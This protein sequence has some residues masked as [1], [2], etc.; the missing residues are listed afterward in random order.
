M[1][2][3][4]KT[5]S[6]SCQGTF[7][8]SALVQ[9]RGNA[10]NI[11]PSPYCS[12]L[13]YSHFPTVSLDL[14]LPPQLRLLGYFTWRLGALQSGLRRYSDIVGRAHLNS[15]HQSPFFCPATAEA[16]TL[17]ALCAGGQFPLA[18]PATRDKLYACCSMHTC[19]SKGERECTAAS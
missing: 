3:R 16:L 7:Q 5:N 2:R 1:R 4:G 11:S 15:A 8:Q 6:P 12:P 19:G 17:Q 10:L 13:I 18:G 9:T 14:S